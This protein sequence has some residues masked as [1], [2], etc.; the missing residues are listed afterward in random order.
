[1]EMHRELLGIAL[2]GLC[3]LTSA[4]AE[5]NTYSYNVSM[6]VGGTQIAGDLQTNCDNNCVL[7]ATT[8]VSFLFTDAGGSF[9]S[10]GVAYYGQLPLEATPTSIVYD[11]AGTTGGCFCDLP[12]Q[13]SFDNFFGEGEIDFDIGGIYNR[14]YYG[15]DAS[16][17]IA[18]LATTPIPSTLLLL[19][20]ALALLGYLFFR[21]KRSASV[22]TAV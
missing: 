13:L 17:T 12:S 14:G 3:S 1:M 4:P 11:T 19:G 16:V 20:S 18:T 2:A 7:S 22:V 15:P 5:A 10:S 21:N 9:S 6:D 8:V